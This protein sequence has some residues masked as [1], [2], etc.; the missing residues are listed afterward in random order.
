MG[1]FD[2]VY[3]CKYW[4]DV[5]YKKDLLRKFS[6]K[7]SKFPSNL[8]FRNDNFPFGFKILHLDDNFT[9][10]IVLKFQNFKGNLNTTFL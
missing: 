6:S 4:C 10:S 8:R 7:N 9:F 5:S 2:I 1:Y 3:F